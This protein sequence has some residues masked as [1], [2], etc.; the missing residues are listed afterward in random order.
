MRVKTLLTGRPVERERTGNAMKE[1][2]LLQRLQAGD[3]QALADLIDSYTAYVY[4]IAKNVIDPPLGPE[5]TEE[6]AADVFLLLWN[7]AGDVEEGKLKPW[8]AAV[9]R[10]RAK[11]RLR[12][13]H[14]PIPLEDEAVDVSFPGPEEGIVHQE[15]RQLARQAVEELPEPDR[16]IFLRYYYLYQKTDEIAAALGMNPATVRTRLARGRDKLRGYLRERGYSCE[17]VNF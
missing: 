17:T 3:A 9:T 8:L 5:D 15:L 6:V 10:N 2:R 12:G 13:L 4:A 1:R 16:G 14:L 11:D 7:H